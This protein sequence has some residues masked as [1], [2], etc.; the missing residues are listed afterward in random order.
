[1]VSSWSPLPAPSPS[2]GPEAST[3]FR[4]WGPGPGSCGLEHGQPLG[5]LLLP[6]SPGFLV[7]TMASVHD[8]GFARLPGPLRPARPPPAPPPGGQGPHAGS[9]HR[10][11]RVAGQGVRSPRLAL[12][13][14]S[15]LGL[16][17]PSFSPPSFRI[18]GP[19]L[20]KL[21][22]L[23]PFKYPETARPGGWPGA[24]GG[25]GRLRPG[26]LRLPASVALLQI[27]ESLWHHI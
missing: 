27:S 11:V 24:R 9:K 13:P 3:A 26:L 20:T 4:S 6:S 16:S 8:E 17:L 7:M 23:G 22:S 2:Q 14:S 25:C 10:A 12:P 1:M 5:L 21:F 18:N 15:S 19:R